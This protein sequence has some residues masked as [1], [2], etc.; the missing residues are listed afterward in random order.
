MALEQL[1][2][3]TQERSQQVIGLLSE[4]SE[5]L[6][7]AESERDTMKREMLTIRECIQD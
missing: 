7:K 5:R 4:L 6:R 2:E 1:S 3:R